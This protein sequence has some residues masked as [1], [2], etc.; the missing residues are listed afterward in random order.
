MVFVFYQ[1]NASPLNFNP[2]ANEAVISSKYYE[3]FKAL[4]KQHIDIETQKKTLLLDGIQDSERAI[5]IALNEQ[6]K[7]LKNQAKTIIKKVAKVSGEKIEENDK[8]YV[9]IHFIVNNLPK[10]I[11]GLLLA[12]ILAAAMSS[13]A[14]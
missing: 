14:S 1:F 3:E 7:I 6:D 10:G 5:I 13:T 12:V 8:D 9:F 4:E 2:K 11:I